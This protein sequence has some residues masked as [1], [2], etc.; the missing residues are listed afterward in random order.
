MKKPRALVG[1]TG[2]VGHHLANQLDFDEYYNSANSSEMRGRY[3]STVFFSAA[4]AE[5]WRANANPDKDL[6]TI[7]GLVELLGSFEADQVVLVSTVDVYDNVSG[8]D[9]NTEPNLDSLHPYGR[10]RLYLEKSAKSRFERLTI[11]RLP[12]LFGEGL[13]KNAIYD[14]IH[15]HELEKI[16]PLSKF[17]FYNIERIGRDSQKAISLDVSLLNL[18]SPPSQIGDIA[19]VLFGFRLDSKISQSPANYDIRSLHAESWNGK[20][21][22]YDSSSVMEDLK[23]FIEEEKTRKRG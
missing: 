16:N 14:L 6:E 13:K 3:F 11:L 8:V 21:Y 4:P 2:F 5:K 20:D 18:C 15:N 23:L 12:A 9:E 7:N 1:H 19:E 22:L 10:N 17:Q